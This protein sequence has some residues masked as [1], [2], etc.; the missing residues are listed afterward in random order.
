MS[1]LSSDGHAH[2]SL[3]S[4][5]ILSCDATWLV[6]VTALDANGSE[7]ANRVAT[8]R[9]APCG[10]GRVRLAFGSCLAVF[11]D[12]RLERYDFEYFLF[13]VGFF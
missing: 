8:V 12:W 11:K 6:H 3:E 2:A 7:L 9:A 1:S 10:R 5:D 4:N 13:G